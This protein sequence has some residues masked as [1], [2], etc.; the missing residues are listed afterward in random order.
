MRLY[1]IR[2]IAKAINVKQRTVLQWIEHCRLTPTARSARMYLIREDV[3]DKF[4]AEPFGI[5]YKYLWDTR[6]ERGHV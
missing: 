1:K 2:E 3:L 5:R 6:K 4:F